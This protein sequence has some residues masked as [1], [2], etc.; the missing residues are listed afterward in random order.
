MRKK[1]EPDWMGGGKG[2]SPVR[3][4]ISCGG[5]AKKSHL[6][7]LILTDEGELIMDRKGNMPGRGGY[8]HENEAC[9]M[10]L[11]KSRSLGRAF[12]GKELRSFSP[13]LIMA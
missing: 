7:R 8:V 4:C 10:G 12:R 9:R 5:K 11:P 1:K 2:H 13:A 3:T 6:I